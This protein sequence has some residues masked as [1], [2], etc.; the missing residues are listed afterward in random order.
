MQA[1]TGRPL[2]KETAAPSGIGSGRK[3]DQ[4]TST[5]ILAPKNVAATHGWNKSNPAPSAAE[6][7]ADHWLDAIVPAFDGSVRQRSL[8]RVAEVIVADI[9]PR[10]GALA[11]A[12]PDLA[13]RAG[14]SLNTC[15]TCVRELQDAGALIYDAGLGR[16]LVSVFAPI[17]P[18]R[19]RASA[20]GR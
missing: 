16:G 18:A 13:R 20:G 17:I 6:T 15:R 19:K 4:R 1:K 11:A 3:E 12:M 8:W 5:S 7:F 2:E 14:V 9:N 10:T